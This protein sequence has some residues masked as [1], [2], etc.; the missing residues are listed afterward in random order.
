MNG[1][2][3][4]DVILGVKYRPEAGGCFSETSGSCQTMNSTIDG[5]R[6]AMKRKTRFKFLITLLFGLAMGVG[7]SQLAASPGGAGD[8][9][10]DPPGS[11][12]GPGPGGGSGVDQSPGRIN[13]IEKRFAT[14]LHNTRKG[15]ETY[16]SAENDGFEKMT[17]VPYEDLSCKNCHNPDA[18]PDWQEPGC[19]DG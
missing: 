18:V 4:M 15:K 13:K 16:Y 2:I 6:A 10:L 14:S 12:P 1:Y 7:S 11:S 19:N 5:E 3:H 17:E 8:F 9:P